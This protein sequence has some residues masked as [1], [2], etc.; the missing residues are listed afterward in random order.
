MKKFL[1]FFHKNHIL[2]LFPCILLMIELLIKKNIINKEFKKKNKNENE[3]FINISH[4][5]AESLI[6]ITIKFYYKKKKIE[7]RYKGSKN[8]LIFYKKK[9]KLFVSYK[10]FIFFI[11]II[12]SIEIFSQIFQNNNII[13]PIKKNKDKTS[14]NYLELKEL[15]ICIFYVL[16]F[17]LNFYNFQY[18]SIST[19]II[20]SVFKIIFNIFENNKKINV[21]IDFLYHFMKEFF[22]VLR[23]ILIKYANHILYINIFLIIGFEGLFNLF[24]YSI[25]YIFSI[26]IFNNENLIQLLNT[27][28]IISYLIIIIIYFIFYLV[29]CQI[30]LKFDPIVFCLSML[31][32]DFLKFIYNDLIININDNSIFEYGIKITKIFF[33]IIHSFALLVFCQIIQLNF[34]N[35][36]K[37]TDINIKKRENEEISQLELIINNNI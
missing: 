2:I 22:Y 7:I 5:L 21:L 13:H 36:N 9:K 37:N 8:T 12:S 15:L 25:F 32:F 26:Y 17:K 14:F 10:F 31:L 4:Y 1:F 3:F 20:T 11:Y 33:T 28:L 35:L 27:K 29:F 16:I 19:F 34:L 23:I 6:L 30:I 24:F 18:L